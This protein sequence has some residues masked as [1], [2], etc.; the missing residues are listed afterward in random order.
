MAD[1][2]RGA[3]WSFE[4]RVSSFEFRVLSLGLKEF[5]IIKESL[6]NKDQYEFRTH[7]LKEKNISPRIMERVCYKRRGR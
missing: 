3:G 5:V 1:S 7:E 4:F 6:N 2:Q